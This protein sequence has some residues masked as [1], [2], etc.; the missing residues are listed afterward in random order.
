[1]RT[2]NIRNDVKLLLN[3]KGA[4]ICLIIIMAFVVFHFLSNVVFYRGYDLMDMYHSM[5]LLML[6]EDGGG[7]IKY[8]FL[9]IFPFLVILPGSF[10]YLKDKQTGMN[11]FWENRQGRSNYYMTRLIAVFLVTFFVFF[12]P[13]LLEI[14]LNCISF[15]FQATGNLMELDAYHA[16]YADYVSKFLWKGLFI[17]APYLYA[18][19]MNLCVAVTAGVLSMLAFSISLLFKI[20][21]KVI[22]F[23]PIYL[24]LMGLVLLEKAMLWLGVSFNYFDYLSLY[25]STP[26]SEVLF[27]GGWVLIVIFSVGVVG[28]VRKGD[29]L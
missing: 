24:I 20:R 4:K 23:F 19:I 13:L 7:A 12:V 26:K 25:D 17:K 9:Q 5:N 14:I 2:C 6:S 11:I 8:F 28:G 16:S 15:P 22:L 1:M 18:V 27:F 3:Q 29:R 21:Y 10:S